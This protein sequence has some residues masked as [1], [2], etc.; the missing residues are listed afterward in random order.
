MLTK[1]QC[2]RALQRIEV[3][4]DEEIVAPRKP[5][6]KRYPPLGLLNLLVV[7]IAA[8]KRTFRNA[9]TMAEDLP[10]DVRRRLDL[11]KAVSDSTLYG[12]VATQGTEGFR[13]T[14]QNQ[15]E[16]MWKSGVVSNDIFDKGVV[17]FDGKG[18]WSSTDTKIEG[19]KES[20]CARD[21]PLWFLGTLRAVLTSSKVRPCV[22]LETIA[23][24]EAESPTFRKM[25]PRVSEHLGK[26][27][28]LVTGEAGL[29][30]RENAA[31]VREHQ[32]DYVFA[33]K[34]NQPALFELAQSRLSTAPCVLST[35]ERTNGRTLV[36]E[37]SRVCV[38]AEDERLSFPGARQLWFVRQ[39]AFNGDKV[40]SMEDR[41]FVTSLG[42]LELG[43]EQILALVR[44]HW[45][46]E[47]GHNWTMDAVLDEDNSQ[48]CQQS[49]RS[50]EVIAWLRV[51][52]Y[53]LLAAWRMGAPTKDRRPISWERAI[54]T[55]RDALLLVGF[56]IGASATTSICT[57][58]NRER[59]L[60][61]VGTR[62]KPDGQGNRVMAPPAYRPGPPRRAAARSPRREMEDRARE[63]PARPDRRRTRPRARRS[64]ISECSSLPPPVDAR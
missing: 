23:A 63:G 30:C 18:T 41:Y 43:P 13:Q 6:G 17:S 25:F 50:I 8:G 10:V 12:L 35:E 48:P 54:E 36:R 4:W 58:H 51:L 56:L 37:L 40:L 57:F 29:T 61:T 34:G 26:R 7:A 62:I 22:D 9:E 45:G 64:G 20:S 49:K 55:L 59:S 1:V 60:V 28:G 14:V 19:A 53:N 31:L 32:K 11:P 46:I 16:K 39:T 15:F 24:K 44:L 42:W 33:V 47:N 2:R 52:A 27:F 5:R 21:K 3:P 38:D